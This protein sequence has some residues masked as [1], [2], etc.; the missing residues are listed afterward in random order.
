MESVSEMPGSF[1]R[2]N[3]NG[4]FVQLV[5]AY[6]AALAVGVTSISG[7]GIGSLLTPRL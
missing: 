4:V 5:L 3:Q 6:V 2:G 7:F 1:A